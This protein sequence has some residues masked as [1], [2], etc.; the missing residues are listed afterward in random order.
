MA[1]LN[2]LSECSLSAGSFSEG[3]LRQGELI[4]GI[5]P[6]L[7][8]DFAVVGFADVHGCSAFFQLIIAVW[9]KL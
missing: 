3:L 4:A 8:D 9:E 6:L 1:F 7:E 2:A 5:E